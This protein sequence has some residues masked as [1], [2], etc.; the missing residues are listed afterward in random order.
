MH[1]KKIL[2][3]L[4][5]LIM[6]MSMAACGGDK[7]ADPTT[8]PVETTA[9]TEATEETTEATEEATEAV[10]ETK[11]AP[12]EYNPV[13][14]K[15]TLT[16]VGPLKEEIGYFDDLPLNYTKDGD[17]YL[18]SL[19]SHEGEDLLGKTYHNYNYLGN[20]LA[21]AYDYSGEKP[22][23]ELVNVETGEILL[24]DGA[25]KVEKIS[26][27]FFYVIYATEVT[28][29]E[30]ECFIYFTDSWVSITPGEDDVLYKGYGKVYDLEKGAFIDAL[31][32]EDP[33][34]DVEACGST[35]CVESDWNVYD[36]YLEDGTVKSGV[37]NVYV[38]DDH[39]MTYDYSKLTVYTTDFTE[40]AVLEKA[41][42]IEMD[43][44]YSDTYFVFKNEEGNSGVM[45]INGNEIIPAKYYGVS[46]I[47]NG[48]CVVYD[49]DF[50]YGLYD[51][52][53]NELLP[54]EYE[55]IYGNDITMRVKTQDDVNCFYFP[56][57][58]LVEAQDYTE[59]DDI[60]YT[61]AEEGNYDLVNYFVLSTGEIITV[62]DY[63]RA[64][65]A[66]IYSEEAGFMELVTGQTLLEGGFDNVKM[67][68]DYI[69]VKKG[70][71][72]TIYQANVEK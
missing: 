60:Y 39:L 40:V 1:M 2:A 34:Q 31:T 21:A 10:E 43:D 23:C 46:T 35:V 69:Y 68:E 20:G 3:A 48:L 41:M 54:C 67:T 55:M 52:G 72:W 8:E 37:E 32:I 47:W 58:G 71:T 18:Y 24:S 16:E 56:G 44:I 26:D 63:E 13:D 6:V 65:I 42:P 50:N 49:Y 38:S 66:L 36:L 12:V 53:G 64:G 19:L 29:N 27:R 62:E 51:L 9:A 7:Q 28:E 30:D 70:G 33:G 11:A 5:A 14:F 17:D 22:A 57:T 45:D 59:A 4:L 25:A 15:V 61:Y